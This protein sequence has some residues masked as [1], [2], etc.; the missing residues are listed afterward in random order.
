LG[1]RL[2]GLTLTNLVDDEVLAGANADEIAPKQSEF[3][4]NAIEL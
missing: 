1:I 4:F 2:L 3:A